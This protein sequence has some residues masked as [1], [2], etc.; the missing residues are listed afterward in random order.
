MFGQAAP[1]GLL[2]DALLRFGPLGVLVIALAI[3]WLFTKPHVE[4]LRKT[5]EDLRTDLREARTDLKR[6][7]EVAS[8]ILLPVA[9]KTLEAINRFN[10]QMLWQ[11]QRGK[12]S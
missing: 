8:E 2:V 7:N 5:M 1:E 6:S 9:N 4:D 3:G 11:Q 10:E 12:A